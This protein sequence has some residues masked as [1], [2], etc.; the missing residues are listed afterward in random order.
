MADL[1]SS[2]L[3]SYP[4]P[5]R[6][7]RQYTWEHCVKM[8]SYSDKNCQ[9]CQRRSTLKIRTDTQTDRQTCRLIIRVV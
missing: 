9:R 3:T 5:R 4:R 2:L 7:L 1:M 8:S 6:S